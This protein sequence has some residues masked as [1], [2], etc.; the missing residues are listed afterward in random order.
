MPVTD[1]GACCTPG[2]HVRIDRG[3]VL[4]AIGKVFLSPPL[5]SRKSFRGV[6]DNVTTS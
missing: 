6:K 2:G 4:S 1:D 5:C 3:R